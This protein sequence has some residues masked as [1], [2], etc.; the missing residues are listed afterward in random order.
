MHIRCECCHA[1]Q[2]VHGIF[3]MQTRSTI[4][5]TVGNPIWLLGNAWLMS[6]MNEPCHP[7]TFLLFGLIEK[8]FQNPTPAV[9]KRAKNRNY[10]CK[11]LVEK[12]LY[13]SQIEQHPHHISKLVNAF[14]RYLIYLRIDLQS[15]RCSWTKMQ[16]N[17]SCF[18][19]VGPVKKMTDSASFLRQQ[20]KL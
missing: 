7:F 16:S 15:A 17:K 4:I 8:M 5:H 10:F 6:A 2:E 19:T 18:A 3:A 14:Q 13:Y 11:N 20:K 9:F 1:L 12:L